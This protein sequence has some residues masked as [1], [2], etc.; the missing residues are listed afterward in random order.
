[1]DLGSISTEMRIPMQPF[2]ICETLGNLVILSENQ[3][4]LCKSNGLESYGK[5]VVESKEKAEQ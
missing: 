2:L 5:H 3:L 4:P 1:M